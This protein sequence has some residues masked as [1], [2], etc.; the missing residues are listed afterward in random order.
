M[1]RG[2]AE[3]IYLLT[4]KQM[5]GY[6]AELFSYVLHLELA[7]AGANHNLTPLRLQ[8]Y[9]S[10]YMSELEPHVLLVFDRSKRRV[11]FFVESAKGQFRILTSCAELE[12]LPEVETALCDEATFVKEDEKLTR[13]VPRADIHQVLQQVAKSLAKLP[14]PS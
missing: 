6:H 11:N 2:N 7:D 8:A 3:E 4:K 13:L 10:V 5:S 12:G 9:Q 14:N 1:R